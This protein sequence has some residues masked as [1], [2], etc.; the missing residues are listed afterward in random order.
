[1]PSISYEGAEL[2]FEPGL[3]HFTHKAAFSPS[4]HSLASPIDC[5][6][7]DPIVFSCVRNC[8]SLPLGFTECPAMYWTI[9]NEGRIATSSPPPPRP[10]STS[11]QPLPHPKCLWW[12]SKFFQS[13]RLFSGSGGEEGTRVSSGCFFTCLSCLDTCLPSPQSSRPVSQGF[14][15]FLSIP[16]SKAVSPVCALPG[17]PDPEE[18]LNK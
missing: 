2:G 6:V 13:L 9:V 4:A 18:A 8:V 5:L 10:S 15:L 3:C 11:P 16:T 14:L 1:M 17:V 7:V 12:Y